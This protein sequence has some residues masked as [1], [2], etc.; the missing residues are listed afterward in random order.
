ME[1]T[2]TH[3]L[4]LAHE[5][6]DQVEATLI[7]DAYNRRRDAGMDPGSCLAPAIANTDTLLAGSV[8]HGTK[9][10]YETAKNAARWCRYRNAYLRDVKP[11]Y[12]T[13]DADSEGDPWESG[14]EPIYISYKDKLDE[15]DKQNQNAL[16]LWLQGEPS[17]VNFYAHLEATRRQH[18]M[19]GQPI[20]NPYD[21]EDTVAMRSLLNALDTRLDSP[22]AMGYDDRHFC[23]AV[24]RANIIINERDEDDATQVE[25]VVQS[26]DFDLNIFRLRTPSANEYLIF[27]YDP[28]EQIHDVD[29]G[30]RI[31]SLRYRLAETSSVVLASIDSPHGPGILEATATVQFAADIAQSGELEFNRDVFSP[32]KALG[33]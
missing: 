25:P 27:L 18:E 30:E 21:A 22:E 19:S 29:S 10:G 28:T 20:T 17:I 9:F 5:E 24:V 26:V 31:E 2:Y 12:L 13:L 7:D 16:S 15:L 1:T 3:E 6:Q 4:A 11:V 33:A 14:L 23:S 8:L 32:R